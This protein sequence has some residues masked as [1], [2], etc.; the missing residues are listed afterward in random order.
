MSIR[1]QIG[2]EFELTPGRDLT[3]EQGEDRVRRETFTEPAS[4]AGVFSDYFLRH[5][6]SVL[7]RLQQIILNKALLSTEKEL[8][9]A[10]GGVV[11]KNLN[12]PQQQGA[13]TALISPPKRSPL[14]TSLLEA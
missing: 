10:S 1:R 12:R 14:A 13:L 7:L 8:P 9:A 6:V 4:T 11:S 3:G 2:S 5:T